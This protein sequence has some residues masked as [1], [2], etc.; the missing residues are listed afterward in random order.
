MVNISI[1]KDNKIILGCKALVGEN[2]AELSREYSV[3]RQYIYQQKENVHKVL[4]DNFETPSS[5]TPTLLLNE[6]V[7]KRTIFGCMVTCKGSIDDTQEFLQEIYGIHISE[8]KISNIMQEYADKA[9]KF[10]QSIPLHSIEVGAHDEIFQAGEPVL[11]GVD[12]YSTFIY[13]MESSNTRDGDAWSYALLDK[14][15]RGL[16]LTQSVNDSGTGLN[17]GI[18]EVFPNISIQSDV[19]HAVRKISLGIH[20]LERTAYKV[21]GQEYHLT[22]RTLKKEEKYQ[23]KYY[24]A[25]IHSWKAIDL[26][27][28]ALILYS[29]LREILRIG[30]YDYGDRMDLLKFILDEFTKLSIKS[31]YVEDGIKYIS[32]HQEELLTFVGIAE[33]EFRKLSIQER[34]DIEALHLMWEQE[35]YSFS[36]PQY[37]YIE[38]RIGNL[39]T[40]QYD[41]IRKKY[42]EARDKLVRA[43]SIVE[44]M[45]SL[46]RPYL[47]LKRV[48][49]DNYLALLQFYLNTRKYSRSR[50]PER[51]GK[52][53]VELLT[54]QPYSSPLEILQGC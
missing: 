46:I 3:N 31:A 21:I 22:D 10:N 53:P 51:I 13:L 4:G 47:F 37:N 18:R 38:A 54:R 1:T 17:K 52:S 48:V 45:N 16:D 41:S 44:C 14:V 43:S 8:G 23:S 50:R 28:N 2:I 12:V 42:K 40:N 24:E 5:N 11:V 49:R 7:I 26:Y 6:E 25:V 39:L 29:W 32:G 27:D 9:K 30:G 19:F 36:S 34:V 20:T 33:Q 15:Y 35:N